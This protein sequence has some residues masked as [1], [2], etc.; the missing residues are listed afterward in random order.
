MF[1]GDRVLVGTLGVEQQRNTFG[2]M[3]VL[4]GSC[5]GGREA[6]VTMVG[7]NAIEKGPNHI[8]RAANRR[9]L[10]EPGSI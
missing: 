6:G 8:A 9:A 7:D 1:A 4:H 5:E 10:P 3:S 2:E